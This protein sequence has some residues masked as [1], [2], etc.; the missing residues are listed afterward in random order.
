MVN[1]EG[2]LFTIEGI[3]ASLIILLTAYIVINST[4]IYTPGDTHISN[5]Q[6]EVTGS[7]ALN[8]LNIA[9]NGTLTKTPLQT[10][11]EQNDAAGFRTAFLNIVNNKSRTTP[12]TIQFQANVTY[13]MAPGYTTI[14]TS[15]LSNSSQALITGDHAVRVTEWVVADKTTKDFPECPG[16]FSACGGKHA[17][18]VEVLLWRD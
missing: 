12:D 11:V 1:N 13:V 7:D 6:L 18:L 14:N 8:M 15:I 9:Q 4:S 10:Y 17:V 3:A 2:Q 5:M 16:T